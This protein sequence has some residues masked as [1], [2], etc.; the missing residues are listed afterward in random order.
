MAQNTLDLT[1]T[2]VSASEATVNVAGNGIDANGITADVKANVDWKTLTADSETFPNASMLCPDRNTNAMTAGNEGV[3]TIT[4]N[5]VPEGYSFKNVTFTS[6]ALNGSGAFQ[7]DNANA[8]P[9]NFTLKQG[10]TVLGTAENVLIKVNSAGGEFVTVPFEVAEAYTATEGTLELTLTLSVTESKG[11]FYGLT[12]ISIETEAATVEPE[13]SV[14]TFVVEAALFP[15]PQGDI[16]EIKGIR[17]EANQG[18]SLSELPTTWT[19]TNEAGTEFA[20][21]TEWLYDWATVL[22]MINPAITEAGTYTL[23]IPAGSLKTDD[24]KECEAAEFSWT[25]VATVEPEPEPEATYYRIKTTTATGD[26]IYLNIGN[27]DEHQTF[28][29]KS[30]KATSFLLSK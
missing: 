30:I 25:I 8:Q 5:N 19:L 18:A 21:S 29:T 27:T 10:E 14:E 4:L 24:G 23:T 16:T 26:A 15:A 12:K 2:K 11:C 3:F 20:M 6:A 7:G 9:V 1:F 28:T 17:V 22:L 13:P